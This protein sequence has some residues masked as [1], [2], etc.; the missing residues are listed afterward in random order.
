[1]RHPFR[2][3]RLPRLLPSIS[4]PRSSP[5]RMK[6]SSNP[7]LRLWVKRGKAQ[8]EHIASV[9]RSERT[10]RWHQAIFRVGQRQTKI[11]RKNK[12]RWRAQRGDWQRRGLAPIKLE[13]QFI[14]EQKLKP[15]LAAAGASLDN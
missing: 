15:S 13:T 4:R 9:F 11:A 10:S 12:M 5:S 8:A 14:V 6:S 3:S 1:M 2:H 7:P